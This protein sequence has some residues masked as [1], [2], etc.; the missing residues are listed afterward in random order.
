MDVRERCR[1][2]LARVPRYVSQSGTPVETAVVVPLARND[3]G[4]W[5]VLFE[6]R[7]RTLRRQP[8]EIAFPGGHVEPYDADPR[9]AAWREAT[10]ELGIRHDQLEYLGALDILSAW[11][12]MFVHPFVACV[13]DGA[14]LRPNP[15]EVDEVIFI[16]VTALL[17]HEPRRAELTFSP[18]FSPDFPF[19]LVPGGRN[20]P[21]RTPRVIQWFYE[22]NG[23]VIWGLTGR[24]L[25]DFLE[26]IR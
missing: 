15:A 2:R 24:I 9:A 25:H 23:V 22:L 16:P 14:A 8:G 21:W 7:A 4:V 12:G 3:E 1:E 17:A 5:C 18:Q 6:R 10:E 26:R 19:H 11:N 13:A 20:Y